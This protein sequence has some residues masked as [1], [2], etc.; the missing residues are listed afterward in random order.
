VGSVQ[1]KRVRRRQQRSGDT[2]GCAARTSRRQCRCG[3][4]A[5]GDRNGSGENKGDKGV[6][7][8]RHAHHGPGT[9][10]QGRKLTQ[11]PS[12]SI[13]MVRSSAN[14]RHSEN[15]RERRHQ[16]GQFR[17]S[18]HP[19]RAH[20][21]NP[22][23]RSSA[24]RRPCQVQHTWRAARTLQSAPHIANAKIALLRSE[25]EKQKKRKF[26]HSTTPLIYYSNYDPGPINSYC[27]LVFQSR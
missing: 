19:Q 24:T 23:P 10:G 7:E 9:Q 12:F 8:R 16:G 25:R 20:T 2:C 21:A 22:P 14:C 5:S 6:S 27:S 11:V 3:G 4:R 1:R 15:L 17:S 13:I 18:D 26:L